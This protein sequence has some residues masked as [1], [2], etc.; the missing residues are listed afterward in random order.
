MQKR[1][2]YWA[3]GSNLDLKQILERCPSSKPMG[4]YTKKGMVLEFRDYANVRFDKSK[5]SAVPGMLYSMTYSDLLKMDTFEHTNIREQEKGKY[6]RE[7]FMISGFKKVYY[8]RMNEK[9]RESYFIYPSSRYEGLIRNAYSRLGFDLNILDRALDTAYK[10]DSYGKY[11]YNNFNSGLSNKNPKSYYVT[12]Y[13]NG[14]RDCKLYDM[15]T[16]QE[17]KTLEY[18]YNSL[19]HYGLQKYGNNTITQQEKTLVKPVDVVRTWMESS[20]P[21]TDDSFWLDS[22]GDV[23]IDWDRIEDDR[24]R[25]MEEIALCIA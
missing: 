14:E 23:T 7:S 3:Y 22:E 19:A 21:L 1:V 17:V 18:D 8:Y 15:E 9:A 5:D 2:I 12:T 25:E 13:T 20:E 24:Q 16:G 11:R 6:R 10:L 4:A